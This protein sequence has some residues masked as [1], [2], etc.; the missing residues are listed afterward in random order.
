M[1]ISKRIKILLKFY[2]AKAKYFKQE[3]LDPSKSAEMVEEVRKDLEKE[4][5]MYKKKIREVEI[6]TLA[7]EQKII[8]ELSLN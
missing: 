5:A 4:M 7:L 8:A 2:K 1:K 3:D 6:R